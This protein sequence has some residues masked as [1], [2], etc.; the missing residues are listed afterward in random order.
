MTLDN[1]VTFVE[2]TPT[3]LH[4]TDHAL[5]DR[6]IPDPLLGFSKRI[7][8]LVLVV[9]EQDG[10]PVAKTLSVT[11]QSLAAQLSGYLADRLYRGYDFVVVRRGAG[12]STRYSVT[13]IPRPG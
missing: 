9:D 8:T 12:F 1:Y 4:F 11:A 7:S 10:R 5:Q 13:A 6:D 3:R 2:G